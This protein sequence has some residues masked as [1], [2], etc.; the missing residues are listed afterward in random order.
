MLSIHQARRGSIS[1]KLSY[2]GFQC[3][4][5]KTRVSESWA[6]Q[7]KGLFHT[8]E[9]QKLLPSSLANFGWDYS[10]IHMKLT[11]MKISILKNN[12]WNKLENCYLDLNIQYTLFQKK[13]YDPFVSLLICPCYL[14]PICRIQRN[15][16]LKTRQ[17]GPINMETKKMNFLPF[18]NK[19]YVAFEVVLAWK[20]WVLSSLGSW[21][22]G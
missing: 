4:M 13:I 18:W 8:L 20:V 21:C 9:F 15:I 6:C 3:S 22:P 12:F 14:D 7:N 1:S 2:P 5:F 16:W 11:N 19:V 17:Q 10:E